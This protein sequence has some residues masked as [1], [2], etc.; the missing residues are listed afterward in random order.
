MPAK[1]IPVGVTQL[2]GAPWGRRAHKSRNRNRNCRQV[3]GLIIADVQRVHVG[4]IAL[5]DERQNHGGPAI[6]AA[7]RVC[8]R[9]RG[10]TWRQHPVGTLVA[11]DGQPD[12]FQVVGAFGSIGGL[13]RLLNCWQQQ[14]DQ[15]GDDGDHNQQLNEAES[16]LLSNL[17][18][19]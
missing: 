19:T 11:H 5:L 1:L 9:S 16:R 18:T 7:G 15:N 10:M 6:T 14:A 8:G 17:A 13:T 12:L 2:M 3:C 4:Q